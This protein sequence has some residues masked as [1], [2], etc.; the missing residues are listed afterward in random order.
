[1]GK[2]S[3]LATPRPFGVVVRHPQRQPGWR[4]ATPVAGG[5]WATPTAFFF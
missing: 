1:M 3:G 2:G 4:A 5:G